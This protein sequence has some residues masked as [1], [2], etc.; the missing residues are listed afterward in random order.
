MLAAAKDYAGEQ[1][2]RG[3]ATRQ[4][5]EIMPAPHRTTRNRH[6]PHSSPPA[7]LPPRASIHRPAHQHTE[8]DADGLAGDEIAFIGAETDQ[9]RHPARLRE[10]RRL[11]A[12]TTDELLA[13]PAVL[14][15]RLPKTTIRGFEK[16]MEERQGGVDLPE[17]E[18]ARKGDVFTL[19][20]YQMFRLDGAPETKRPKRL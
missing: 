6:P 8:S 13:W 5:F 10:R 9:H 1:R 19:R 11:I 3:R 7:Q 17:P 16:V 15:R 2:E 20:Q 14:A 4:H 18:G 12:L